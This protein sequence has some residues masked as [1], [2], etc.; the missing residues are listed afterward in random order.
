MKQNLKARL[1]GLLATVAVFGFAI[2]PAY[3]KNF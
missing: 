2:M 3:M 1:F